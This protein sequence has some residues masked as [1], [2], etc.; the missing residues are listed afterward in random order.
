MSV[1][2][3]LQK[4]KKGT[5]N[6]EEND[7]VLE[8]SELLQLGKSV[9][10]KSRPS[11]LD[12]SFEKDHKPIKFPVPNPLFSP[13]GKKSSGFLVSTINYTARGCIL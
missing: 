9:L 10:F 12:M 2:N 3:A 1:Y 6:H 8:N 13:D 11:S 4:Q 7:E 5:E